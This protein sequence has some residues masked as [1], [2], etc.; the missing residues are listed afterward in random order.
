MGAIIYDLPQLRDPD[1]LVHH[2]YGEPS[3][4]LRATLCEYD[5]G[6]LTVFFAP[7][8]L[9]ICRAPVT[10]L[11]CMRMREVADQWQL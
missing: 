6:T 8:D 9:S 1:G 11:R 10:C 3:D 4:D 2:S 7:E 5:G